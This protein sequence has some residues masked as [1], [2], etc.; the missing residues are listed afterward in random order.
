MTHS[1]TA[2]GR[3]IYRSRAVLVG[4]VL[5]YVVVEAWLAIGILNHGCAVAITI[6][7]W[8]RSS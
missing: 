2:Q 1:S 8:L 3:P 6:D 5:I 4:I 7:E